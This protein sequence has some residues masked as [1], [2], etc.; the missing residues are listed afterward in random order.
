[1]R[2]L[3]RMEPEV[4][5]N[6]SL[7]ALR[8]GLAGTRDLYQ[9][10]ALAIR[11]WGLQF[12]NPLGIAAGF[13]KNAA[14]IAGLTALGFGFV[15]VGSITPR[16]QGGNPRPRLFRLTQARAVINRMGFNNEG[17]EVAEANIR[18]WRNGTGAARTPPLGIN[19]GKN[20]DSDDALAD[21]VMG[22]RRLGPYA[23]YVTVN[24]SS[25]NTPGLRDLQAAKALDELIAGLQTVRAEMPEEARP[26][27]LLKIAPDLNEA[28]LAD[29]AAIALARKLDGLIVSNTTLARP[30]G[31]DPVW[32]KEA[33]G[34]SGAPL[35]Q[36]STAVLGQVYRLTEGRIPLIGVGGIGSGRDAYAKVRAGASLLQ[37]YSALTFEGSGLIGRILR[38][39]SALLEG[40]RYESLSQAVGADH[41]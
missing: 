38:D 15:E 25:P 6:L 28:D 26:P 12:D 36:L 9:D 41:R 16:S 30:P 5:H 19:L 24:V 11:L 35:F 21:Y 23:D 4:A 17:L 39:L 18:A 13:D 27:L 3:Q 20:K 37:L 7:W 40:D 2:L 29:I 1:M 22:L 8:R 31:L 32:A 33:G 34:L 14:A 10:P